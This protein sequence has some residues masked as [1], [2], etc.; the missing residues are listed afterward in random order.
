MVPELQP[1]SLSERL[2]LVVTRGHGEI[3]GED[4]GVDKTLTL[5]LPVDSFDAF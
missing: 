2:Q 1:S 5:R 3:L 4:F